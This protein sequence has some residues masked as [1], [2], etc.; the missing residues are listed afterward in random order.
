MPKHFN[1][2]VQYKRHQDAY[3]KSFYPG[4]K[5]I[6]SDTIAFEADDYRDVLV[7]FKFVL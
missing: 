5:L 1:I 3:S 4:C 7:A 2:E 6:D